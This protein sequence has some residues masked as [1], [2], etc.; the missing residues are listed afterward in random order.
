M[1]YSTTV[2][3][4]T[5][6]PKA[7]VRKPVS[8]KTIADKSKK[9]PTSST[10]TKPSSTKKRTRKSNP[11]YADITLKKLKEL[12]GDDDNV[13]VKVSRNFVLAKQEER[14]RKQ[15]AEDLGIE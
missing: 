5:K 11:I 14:L 10:S 9:K 3:D 1:L 4:D 8:K 15:A 6:E 13:K 2:M 7:S 12:L